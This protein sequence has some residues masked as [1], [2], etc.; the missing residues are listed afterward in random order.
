MVKLFVSG[1]SGVVGYGTLKSLRAAASK[2]QL[3]GSSIYND[4]V[5]PLFCD[6]F[7]LA[8]PT[9]ADHYLNWLSTTLQENQI[10]LAFPG[11][12][13][14]M[15]CWNKNRSLIEASGVKLMLNDEQLIHLSENKWAFYQEL[16]KGRLSCAIPTSISSDYK[17]VT[18]DFGPNIIVKPIAGFGSKG[19]SKPRNEAEFEAIAQTIGDTH[20]V[21]PIIG[22]DGNEYSISAFCHPTEG[23]CASMGLKRKLSNDGYTQHAEVIDTAPFLET[24]NELIQLFR[25]I[26]PTNFQ[27]RTQDN[28]NYLL[29]VNPRISSATSIRTA[30]GYNEAEMAVRFFLENKLPSQPTILRGRA[31]RYIEDGIFYEN[32]NHI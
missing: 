7:V 26:G 18:A 14:D 15:R 5:A 25:P 30:F 24:I 23:V 31:T 27:F 9:N 17:T 10:Q 22:D 3:F 6:Q 11:I 16:E 13:A 2:S 20:I 4:S 28:R 12:E 19:I 21:Q 29:E 8:P 1:A 32:S